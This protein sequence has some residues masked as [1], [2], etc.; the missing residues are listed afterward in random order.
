MILPIIKSNIILQQVG[1]F[2]KS[3]ILSQGRGP[4]LFQEAIYCKFQAWKMTVLAVIHFVR[5]VAL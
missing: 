2:E 1:Y 3:A 4:L 5:K